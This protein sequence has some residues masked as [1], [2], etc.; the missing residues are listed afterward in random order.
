MDQDGLPLL[1]HDPADIH[2]P[3]DRRYR[4]QAVIPKHRADPDVDHLNL[5]PLAILYPAIE[6]AS[7]KLADCDHKPG[8]VNLRTQA[9]HQRLVE[10]LR[11]MDSDTER[12]AAEDPA[13][14][15]DGGRIGRKVGVDMLDRV[16]PEPFPQH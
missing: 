5:G 14:H 15:C 9:K 4:S 10:L 7:G 16:L 8:K 3:G 12:W 6:L 13:Q 1:L 11:T 2:Q